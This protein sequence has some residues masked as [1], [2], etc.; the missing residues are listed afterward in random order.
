MD[1]TIAHGNIFTC[2]GVQNHLVSD[3]WKASVRKEYCIERRWQSSYNK[4]HIEEERRIVD[5]LQR[6]EGSSQFSPSRALLPVS[7]RGSAG[8]SED[9]QARGR[10]IG[11]GRKDLLAFHRASNQQGRMG[12]AS[13]D[14]GG[15]SGDRMNAVLMA[16][17]R[18]QTQSS[19]GRKPIIAGSFFRK[20][21]AF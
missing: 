20:S 9:S 6:S 10:G 18:G 3:M 8:H 15:R 12:T 5:D 13:R 11:M 1:P 17:R 21:G 16:E 2:R 19:H 7:L 14:V 4:G